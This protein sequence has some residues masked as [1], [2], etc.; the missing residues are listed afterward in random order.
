MPED[1]LVL[2]EE[3][4]LNHLADLAGQVLFN[5]LHP[6]SIEFTDE[7]I[8]LHRALMI[9]AGVLTTKTL[10]PRFKSPDIYEFEENLKRLSFKRLDRGDRIYREALRQVV[11]TY[12]RFLMGRTQIHKSVIT[13]D[14]NSKGIYSLM[15]GQLL[16]IETY[17]SIMRPSNPSDFHQTFQFS[18]AETPVKDLFQSLLKGLF[19]GE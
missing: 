6:I 4:N 19:R 14:L 18:T 11:K 9:S 17:R 3:I 7:E 15:L 16:G 12:Y 2:I 10:N 1:K 8:F 13:K 5:I